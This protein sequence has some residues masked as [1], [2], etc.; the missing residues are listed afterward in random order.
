MGVEIVMPG[1]VGPL[2][3]CGA[4]FFGQPHITNESPNAKRTRYKGLV[5]RFT[6]ALVTS[7]MLITGT[8]RANAN[9]PRVPPS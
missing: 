5:T 8:A 6:L 7:L 2:S 9:C 1:V 3:P 4:G